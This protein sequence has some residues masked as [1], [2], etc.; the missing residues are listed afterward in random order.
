MPQSGSIRWM[1]LKSAI[2]TVFPSAITPSACVPPS[3]RVI[4]KLGFRA[5]GVSHEHLFRFGRWWDHA[6][7]EML[8]R[9][10]RALSS[11]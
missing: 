11:S 1:L 4:E 8:E 9:E 5:V 2:Q 6:S 3:M 10:W 7:F